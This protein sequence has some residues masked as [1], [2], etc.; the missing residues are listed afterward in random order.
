MCLRALCANTEAIKCF[1]QLLLNS[2][3]IARFCNVQLNDHRS[4]LQT[5]QSGR[6]QL[7]FNLLE[8]FTVLL[9]RL[10]CVAPVQSSSVFVHTLLCVFDLAYFTKNHTRNSREFLV[11]VLPRLFPL[12]IVHE[13]AIHWNLKLLCLL[14]IRQAPAQKKNPSLEV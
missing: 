3:V 4:S 14:R 8:R 6:A 10:G 13:S 5:F 2:L 11:L 12:H 1:S 7:L 9:L